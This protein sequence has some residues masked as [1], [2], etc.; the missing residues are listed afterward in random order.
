[1]RLTDEHLIHDDAERPPVTELVVPG[2]HEHLGRNVVR[3]THCG[4]SL[5]HGP[6]VRAAG[7]AGG[8]PGV[9]SRDWLRGPPTAT[10]KLSK[11][12]AH[13]PEHFPKEQDSFVSEERPQSPEFTR[14]KVA[15]VTT[16]RLIY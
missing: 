5:K 9:R 15:V 6:H 1:M 13:L 8:C 7:R 11:Q 12:M 4:E 3:S 16:S 14:S 2:L 10:H